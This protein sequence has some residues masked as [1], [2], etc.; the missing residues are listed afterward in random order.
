MIEVLNQQNRYNIDTKKF[1]ILLKRLMTHYG[2]KNSEITL[3]FVNNSVI[4]KLNHKF[5]NKD[6][7]TDVLSFCLGEYAADGKFYLG[8]IIISVPQ[9]AKQSRTK[10]HSLVQ[11]LEILAIHGYLHL[12]GFEHFKGLEEEEEKIQKIIFEG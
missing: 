1:S 12:K 4:K 5:R 8:D 2:Q 11:E 3:A 7:P 9:A 6:A 10:K